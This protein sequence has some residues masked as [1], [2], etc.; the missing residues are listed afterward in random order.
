MLNEQN[1]QGAII[2]KCDSYIQSMKHYNPELYEYCTEGNK[3][4][5]EGFLELVNNVE[6]LT[7]QI[8]QIY[9]E[10][11]DNKKSV[12]KNLVPNTVVE[13]YK[14]K[15]SYSAYNSVR[16]RLFKTRVPHYKLL[17][18]KNVFEDIIKHHKG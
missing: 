11:Q 8:E 16:R 1:E 18:F 3:M 14:Y 5:Y 10:I 13:K 6:K 9:F 15:N 7:Y 12:T 2:G 17:F 4:F